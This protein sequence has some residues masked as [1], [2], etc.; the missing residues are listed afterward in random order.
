MDGSDSLC[1]DGEQAEDG[2][3]PG[4]LILMVGYDA[5]TTR[6]G[7]LP[8]IRVERL[9]EALSFL[10]QNEAA[11]IVVDLD[12]PDTNGISTLQ[13]LLDRTGLTPV[14]VL[15]DDH[16]LALKALNIGAFSGDQNPSN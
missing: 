12:L 16:D 3:V 15:V 1:S 11:V 9:A 2:S 6:I 5:R 8:V 13:R 10:D 14:V 7:D 4:P